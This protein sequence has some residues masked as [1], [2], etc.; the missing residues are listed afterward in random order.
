MLNPKSWRRGEEGACG[1]L[2]DAAKSRI[3]ALRKNANREENWQFSSD[4]TASMLARHLTF[5]GRWEWEFYVSS[6]SV[7]WTRFLGHR[8]HI[9][10][11]P[12]FLT[13]NTIFE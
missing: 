1:S 8:Y 11:I 10:K 6:H 2:N 9:A 5:H 13:E 7:K 12:I 4:K 3:Q